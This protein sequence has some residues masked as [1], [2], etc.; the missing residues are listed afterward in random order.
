[1]H[2][3]NNNR[4]HDRDD[5]EATQLLRGAAVAVVGAF[6]FLLCAAYLRWAA[7]SASSLTH[8]AHVSALFI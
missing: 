6:V 5:T 8:S 3:G 4:R 2:V 7:P 1:M